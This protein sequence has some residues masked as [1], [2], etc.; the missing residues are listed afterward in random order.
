MEDGTM[1]LQLSKPKKSGIKV[2][3]PVWHMAVDE[4]SGLK[5]SGFYKKKDEM[6]EP[7]RERIHGQ[8]DDKAVKFI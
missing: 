6:V 4:F 7:M 1:T 2:G 5:M 3:R 8:K